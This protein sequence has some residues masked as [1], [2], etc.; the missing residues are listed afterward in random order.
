[1][2]WIPAQFG[3][4]GVAYAV[5]EPKEPEIE[6]SEAPNPRQLQLGTSALGSNVKSRANSTIPYTSEDSSRRAN[7][8]RRYG[9]SRTAAG[10]IGTQ[11]AHNC[12]RA[13]SGGDVQLF[14]SDSGAAHF[15]G[16]QTCGSVWACA[17]CSEKISR[18]RSAELTNAIENWSGQT[19][20]LTLTFS[21]GRNDD[22]VELIAKQANAR[23]WLAAQRRYKNL[24]AQIG[25]TKAQG[26]GTVRAS[27][28]THAAPG[29][30]N[31]NGWHP[32]SHEAWFTTRTNITS[33]EVEEFQH[34]LS[35]LWIEACQ[36]VGLAA[37]DME[38]GVVASME[39]SASY[40]AKWGLG[41]ELTRSDLKAGN[42]KGLTPWQ[43]LQIAHDKGREWKQAAALFREY[44]LAY[45]GRR[46]LTYSRGLKALMGIANKTDA[47]LVSEEQDQSYANAERDHVITL[48]QLDWA[49]VV[50]CNAQTDMLSACEHG[51]KDAVTGLLVA[52]TSKAAS[53]YLAHAIGPPAG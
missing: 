49:V 36:K 6:Q 17:C 11:T 18:L 13:A 39:A 48:S 21:H 24:R 26:G 9:M 37:P 33:A 47:E 51:G 44:A 14:Q 40:S 23:K 25:A 5:P 22:L 19:I 15:R 52:L 3:L 12:G 31:G 46:Q 28:V 7:R 2:P 32:H 45:R 16:V 42:S 27:E 20:S 10:I 41:P 53:G 38:H 1:M 43:L 8:N 4:D 35:L 34:T 30:P 50:S 29:T